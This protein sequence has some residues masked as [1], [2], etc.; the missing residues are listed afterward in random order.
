MSLSRYSEIFKTLG[1]SGRPD[2]TAEGDD[3]DQGQ[4]F[5]LL[6]VDDEEGV[7]SAMKR[8]FME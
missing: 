4:E 6:F 2:P 3:T 8:I 5:T 7:L 1:A